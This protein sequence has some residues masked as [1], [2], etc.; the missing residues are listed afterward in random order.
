[1]SGLTARIRVAPG[2]RNA[3]TTLKNERMPVLDV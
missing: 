1:M 3:A 2:K